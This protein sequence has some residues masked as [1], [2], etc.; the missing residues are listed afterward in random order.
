MR[1]FK[2]VLC[3]SLSIAV[4]SSTAWAQEE[5]FAGRQTLEVLLTAASSLPV[6][7]RASMMKEAATIWR[8][9]GVT[10]EWLPATAQRPISPNR[11]RVLVVER[12]QQSANPGEP[13]TVGELLRPVSGHPVAMMS[14]QSAQRLV[15]SLR[16]RAGYELA[17]VDQRRLGLVLGR[18]LAHEIGHYLLD[19]HTH[20]RQGLMRPQFNALEFTDRRDETFALDR[21]ASAW[22]RSHLD[23]G[24]D[25]TRP[26]VRFAY[27]H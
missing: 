4:G 11:L 19:T 9:Q 18:A 17:A 2:S 12:Q 7:A 14:I 8:D 16:G 15:A 26:D 5:V 22:L 1:R 10:I 13:F 3:L 25:F 20:A 24:P 21:V 6:A 27:A 23:I